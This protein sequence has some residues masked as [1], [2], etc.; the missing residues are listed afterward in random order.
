MQVMIAISFGDR[1]GWLL[2]LGSAVA[3][4]RYASMTQFTDWLSIQ[5]S[6]AA[7]LRTHLTSR[8]GEMDLGMMPRTPRRQRST[9]WG[10]S[11]EAAWTMIMRSGAR[12]TIAGTAWAVP[13]IIAPSSRR[14]S[15]G[16][17]WTV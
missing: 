15:A 10:S 4:E 3:W 7:I 16:T 14:T 6:P 13:V 11:V 5:V 2:G 1:R 12:R 8:S 17:R 9:W